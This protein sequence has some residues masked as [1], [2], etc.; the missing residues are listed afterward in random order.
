MLDV[1]KTL[2]QDTDLVVRGFIG[3]GSPFATSTGTPSS[4]HD[5]AITES[6]EFRGT[7]AS[8]A[9]QHAQAR[10]RAGAV[11]ADIVVATPGRLIDLISPAQRESQLAEHSNSIRSGSRD[12]HDHTLHHSGGG[13]SLEHL[14]YLVIDEADRFVVPYAH[15]L[16]L[17]DRCLLDSIVCA[18][19]TR[20]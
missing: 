19:A 14:S 12:S 6:S 7:G 2:V 4:A 1:F 8:N 17:L 15:E 11:A 5:A 10:H 13:L 3:S 16:L 20:P 9:T 18:F